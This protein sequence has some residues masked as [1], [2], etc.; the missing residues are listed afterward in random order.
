MVI[1]S[2]GLATTWMHRESQHDQR[3]RG[4]TRKLKQTDQS[5][6]IQDR[7]P[8]PWAASVTRTWFGY[9]AELRLKHSKPLQPQRIT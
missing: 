9:G 3:R 8:K 2:H 6:Q 5:K 4:R 1:R 7:S